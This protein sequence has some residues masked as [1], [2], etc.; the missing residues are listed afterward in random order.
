[1]DQI[2]YIAVTYA[3]V[4]RAPF[5]A[6]GYDVWFN[7]HTYDGSVYSFIALTLS[8]KKDFNQ[9]VDFMKEQMVFI[10]KMVI[11]ILDAL[12]SH[13][14]LSYYLERIDKEQSKD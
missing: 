6:I 10:L 4:P 7:I 12:H 2:D 1:M 8:G 9:A 13:E 3:K 5:G 11:H 14:H